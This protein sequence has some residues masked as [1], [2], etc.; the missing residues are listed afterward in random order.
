MSRNP[1]YI[2]LTA[3]EEKILTRREHSNL[4]GSHYIGSWETAC[5]FLDKVMGKGEKTCRKF[6][7]IL[8]D[9]RTARVYTEMHGIL[10]PG[11]ISP[12]NR[13]F[14]YSSIGHQTTSPTSVNNLGVY[15]TDI[16]D[17]ECI[18][19]AVMVDTVSGGVT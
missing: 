18:T 2:L 14:P 4:K 7:D 15:A 16:A 19:A 12:R 3:L 1:A 6:L 10:I 5:N 11:K 17:E 8:A 13:Q 9:E